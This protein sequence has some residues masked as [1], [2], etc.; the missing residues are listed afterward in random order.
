MHSI[1]LISLLSSPLLLLCFEPRRLRSK[2]GADANQTL[3]NLGFHFGRPDSYHRIVCQDPARHRN[4]LRS[5]GTV[6]F[7]K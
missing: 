2:A 5:Q 6:L 7:R 3:A 4:L 1:G